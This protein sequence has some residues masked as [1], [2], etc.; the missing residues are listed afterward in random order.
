MSITIRI[1]GLKEV[2]AALRDLPKST[3]KNIMRRVLIARAEP[4]AEAARALVPVDKGN[5]LASIN[6]STR[7]T[8]RQR[9]LHRKPHR[10][11][12]EVHVGPG[13]NPAG[14]F[15]EFG[16]SRHP[17]QPFMRPAWDRTKAGV[18]EGLKEDLWAEIEKVLERRA[19]R[20]ARKAAK[21]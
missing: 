4:V 5:L 11:D 17:A 2:Q 19:R 21:G 13:A 20:A 16:T 10:D 7:L 18:I 3:G 6:V 15:Q 12:V 8:R 14:H 9:G 1:E